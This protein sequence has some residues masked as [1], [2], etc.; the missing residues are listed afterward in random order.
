M[1]FVDRN[2]VDENGEEIRS[3]DDWFDTAAE[4]TADA[5]AE[6]DAHQVDDGVY[7]HAEVRKS[8]EKLFFDKCAYCEWK[9]TGGSDWDVEHYRPK[10][11][12]YENE[13][14]PGYYWLVYTWNN[15]FLSC[16]HCNQ[17]RLSLIHI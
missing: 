13:H 11:R 1:I 16:T 9:P 7:A 2:A 17:K 3:N 14:H 4:R 10:G 15:L 8:L 6:G 12:V 5:I